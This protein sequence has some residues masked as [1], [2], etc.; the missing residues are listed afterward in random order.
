MLEVKTR[1]LLVAHGL[2]RFVREHPLEWNGRIHRYDFVF[3]RAR[4]VVETNGRRWHD[5]PADYAALAGRA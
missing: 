1:R 5:D 2:G 3:E 4:V